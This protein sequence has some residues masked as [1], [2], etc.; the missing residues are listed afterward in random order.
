MAEIIPAVL[1]KSYAEL[2]QKL[3]SIDGAA[4]VVQVDLV[5]GVF[6]PSKT[7]P[8]TDEYHWQQILAQEE[9]MPLWESFDFQFDLMVVDAL[10]YARGAV[11]AGASSVVLHRAGKNSKEVL[12][13]LQQERVGEFG[14]ALGLALLP[15]DRAEEFAQ[16]KELV[17]FVQVMGI[18]KVGV[19]GSEFDARAI[20]LITSL[21]AND[22]T[23]TIQIDGGVTL[24][25]ARALARAGANRL[26]TG[27]AVFKTDDTH[28]AVARLVREA[29]KTS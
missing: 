22:A 15:T 12:E 1:P 8:F 13:A 16:Y 14:V 9:G 10:T 3:V 4:P 23:L 28:E 19:Q 6:A 7:W 17:D 11:A 25:N 21:R 27:S 2:E 18:E 20:D 5:D 29:N 26:V 24:E